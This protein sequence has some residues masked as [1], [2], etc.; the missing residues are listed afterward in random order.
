MC[1]DKER[2][3]FANARGVAVGKDDADVDR[4]MTGRPLAIAA[5]AVWLLYA[6]IYAL[7]FGLSGSSIGVAVRGGLANA[8]PD[9][10]L[11]F[12]V[13]AV[14][15]RMDWGRAASGRFVRLH[16]LRAAA[17]VPAAAA[18]K[19]LLIWVDT[20]AHHRTFMFSPGV[21]TWQLFLSGLI[22]VAVAATSHT[23]LIA[24]R[25][26]EEEANAARADAL[27]VRAEM[28]A[29]RAQLNPH[30]LFNTLHSVLGMVRRDPAQAETALEKL[31]D[32]LH[33]AIRVHRDGVDWTALGRE[34]EFAET[35]LDL[36]RIRL[37]DRLQVVRRLDESVL[38]EQ[39]PT[40]SLQ[41]LVENAVRHG[42]APRAAGGRI[43]IEA[44]VDRD[45]LHIEIS[46]DGDGRGAAAE[47]DEGGLG[48]RV[49]RDRLEVL[50]RGAAQMIAGPTPAGGYRVAMTLPLANGDAEGR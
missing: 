31:G 47:A 5:A 29:L 14:S 44:H 6:G 12:A 19:T 26:R 20:V 35:Y 37:G 33:Y 28:A 48:L 24:R 46:N 4:S 36:E 9:G 42:I 18:C 49:L 25:L 17:L 8:I 27:R 2:R 22:Y 1:P 3:S 41:P 43:V 7:S 15:R 21:V 45:M 32:L 11:A 16:S 40:F 13:V 23:W 10:L 38:D 50:Y 30:F 34:W 39:V